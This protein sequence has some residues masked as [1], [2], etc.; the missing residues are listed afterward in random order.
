M[1]PASWRYLERVWEQT[2]FWASSLIFVIASTLVPKLLHGIQPRDLWLLPV[3]IVAA[4]VARAVVLFGV[5]P[6]SARYD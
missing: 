2:G 6:Y 4:F 1:R 5:L 3:A